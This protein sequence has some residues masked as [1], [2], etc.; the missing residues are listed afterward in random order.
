M[1]WQQKWEAAR[2]AAAL[3][4]FTVAAESMAQVIDD[5]QTPS[6]LIEHASQ[7]RNQYLQN[8]PRSFWKS[9]RL[10]MGARA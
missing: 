3:G 5:E 4:N 6:F 2:R 8:Q 1:N 10:A 7:I 9:L